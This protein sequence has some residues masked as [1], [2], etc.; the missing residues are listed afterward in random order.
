M[1]EP[2]PGLDFAR[3]RAIQAAAGEVIAFVD[4]DA[5]ADSGWLAALRHALAAHPRRGRD[6]R[7]GAA[8][9]A[10]TE[11]QIRFEQRGGFE[12]V[13]D[14]TLWRVA[15]G[16][17][18]LPCLGGKFGTG[19]NMAFRRQ[20]LIELGGFDEALDTGAALPGGRRHRYVL[21]CRSAGT[22]WSTSHSSWSFTDTAER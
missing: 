1:V 7:P 20:V 11:A 3:N 5:Q 10:S 2:K 16:T 12:K 19:C 21:P 17:P 14:G 18:V 22:R 4:D 9:R 13:R 6:H 15:A 8:C